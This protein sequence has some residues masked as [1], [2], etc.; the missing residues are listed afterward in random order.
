MTPHCPACGRVMVAPH[1]TD[2]EPLVYLHC[3]NPE[4]PRPRAALEILCE[5]EREHILVL[6]HH[7][8]FSLKHPLRERL[9][10]ELLRCDVGEWVAEFCEVMVSGPTLG[11]WKPDRKYQVWMEYDT[12][13]G[14]GGPLVESDTYLEGELVD[15]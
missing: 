12:T 8:G 7:G 1:W 10:G 3:R 9:D 11:D 6:S 5:N 2:S 13:P 4:C 15:G 14:A